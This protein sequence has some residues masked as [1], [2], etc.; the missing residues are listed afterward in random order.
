MDLTLDHQNNIN[1]I[2][3]K[4]GIGKAFDIK[5]RPIKVLGKL[6]QLYYLDGMVNNLEVIGVLEK[7]LNLPSN[8]ETEDVATLI[9]NNI[10]HKDSKF[11]KTVEEVYEHVLNGVLVLVIE[12]SKEAVIAETR[13]FPTRS[14][15][16]P[17]LEKVIRGSH[18]GFT[19][20]L[21]QN[22]SLVR[23]RV[24]D[25]MMRNEI[26]KVGNKSSFNVCLSYIEGIASEKRVEM[27]RS[28]IQSVHIDHLI[29]ADKA[30]EELMIKKPF[31]LYPLVRY[32][33]RADIVAVH[34][35]RGKIA[36]FVD[37]S[38]SVIIGPATFFDHLQHVE[39]HRQTPVAG[40]YLRLIRF[41]GVFLS[42]FLTPLWL[43]LLKYEVVL[44]EIFSI[45]IPDDEIKISIFLQIVAAEIGVEFLRMASIHTP[46]SLSTAMG[47]VAG[48]L[49][50]DVAMQVGVFSVQT[51]F[52]VAVSAIGSYVTPSYELSLANKLVKLVF[53]LV[54]MLFGYIGFIV[55]V[56]LW[57]IY[58]ACLKSLD[59][60]YL[61][62]L[63]PF[64]WYDLKQILVRKPIKEVKEDAKVK[65]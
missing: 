34:L 26:Y 7:I 40:S 18:D 11:I 33:E 38:P 27:A 62:P 47:L 59:R 45:F 22:I 3:E 30:L 49:I 2:N 41:V 31:N 46:S 14:I 61:Y 48:I 55:I 57:I 56:V 64:N 50:G 5:T 51:V 1:L 58:L 35:Y 4:L 43:L 10:T 44:P 20:S 29:M 52:L 16:E 60:P 32:T 15:S 24:K 36:I 12:G 23:R 17:D 6:V 37:T 65:M 13:N 9:Y 53:L 39:E 19:E 28:R 21:N 42:L 8:S 54:I 63:I 25:G